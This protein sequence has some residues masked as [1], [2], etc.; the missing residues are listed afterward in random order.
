MK[1]NDKNSLPSNTPHIVLL[2]ND[3]AKPKSME[4]KSV[5]LSIEPKSLY[6]KEYQFYEFYF[7]ALTERR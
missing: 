3:P 2:H 1:N 6:E 4:N 7:L 5:E